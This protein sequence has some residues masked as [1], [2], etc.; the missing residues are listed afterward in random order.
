MMKETPILRRT[1]KLAADIKGGRFVGL[2]GALAAE[3]GPALGPL[4]MD[5]SAGENVA[6]TLLGV[7]FP[8]WPAAPLQRTPG[9]RSAQTA[10]PSS[11]TP[12]QTP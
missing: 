6:V 10:R 5:G 12:A 1:V 11:T 4:Y 2:D 8:W 3:N 9:W 7:T